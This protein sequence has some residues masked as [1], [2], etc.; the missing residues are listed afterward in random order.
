[1]RL[2]ELV[3]GDFKGN[4]DNLDRFSVKV[5]TSEN[6]GQWNNDQYSPIVVAEVGAGVCKAG[7][8]VISGLSI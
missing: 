5:T 6:M 4:R 7:H 2:R 1:M 3:A 8:V